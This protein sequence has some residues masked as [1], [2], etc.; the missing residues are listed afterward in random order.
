MSLAF[1]RNERRHCSRCGLPLEDP[2]S[3]ERGYG[4]ICARKDNNLYAK[5]IPANYSFALSVML[6]MDTKDLPQAV[7]EKFLEVKES[8]LKHNFR[9]VEKNKEE[10]TEFT[11]KGE[12]LRKV[13]KA[14]D[15]MLSFR[16]EEKDRTLLVSVVKWLGYSSLAAV[17]SQEASTSSAAL[18]F[19]DGFI[20][21]K[22]KACKAGF[23]KMR[24]IP[25]IQVPTRRGS[26]EPYIAPVSQIETFLDV[27]QG[28]WPFYTVSS[29]NEKPIEGATLDTLR[30]EAEQWVSKNPVD[31]SEVV[32]N[33]GSSEAD[34][35]PVVLIRTSGDWSTVAF[36][37][38][39][40]NTQGM[41]GLVAKIKAFPYKERK[42]N[43]SAK[44]WSVHRTRTAEL[45]NIL[46]EFF[47]VREV[48]DGRF[49]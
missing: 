3:E 36:P 33:H 16:M 47:T 6:G 1:Q 34:S 48:R 37:W 18:W 38:L 8:L 11:M 9:A 5:T 40:D 21:L 42:Y 19:K 35:K 23:L 12:D 43:P 39:K 15:W 26:G 31:E 32:V 7:A 13:I 24:T 27:V 29:P 28:Y 20:Y 45:A 22:G 2:A 25:G 10:E 49:N 17:L 14:L 44:E 30:Q 41:Y 46:G 4:P